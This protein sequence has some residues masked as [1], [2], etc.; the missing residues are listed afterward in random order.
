MN[1][2]TNYLEIKFERYWPTLSRWEFFWTDERIELL[3]GALLER[4][5]IIEHLK[6]D[7]EL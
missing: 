3:C 5:D 7:M 6:L 4:I 2:L 1:K